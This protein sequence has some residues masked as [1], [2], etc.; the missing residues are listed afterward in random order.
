[1][2]KNIK[3]FLSLILVVMMSFTISSFAFAINTTTS[4]ST[5]NELSND[6]SYQIEC[7]YIKTFIR[8]MHNTDIII[9]DYKTLLDTNGKESFLYVTFSNNKSTGYAILNLADM[10]IPELSLTNLAPFTVDESIIYLGPLNY[11]RH[12]GSSN[13]DVRTGKVVSL[14][15]MT[16][17]S[18]AFQSKTSGT[19][20]GVEAKQ[21]ALADLVANTTLATRVTISGAGSSSWAYTAG[22]YYGDCGINAIAMIEKWYDTYVSSNYLPSNLSTEQ[23]IKKSIYDYAKSNNYPTT[24][25]SESN[26]AG[27]ITGH[28]E[29][30]GLSGRYLYA[31]YS[32]YNW[33]DTCDRIDD[34]RPTILST[35]SSTPTYGRHYIIAVGYTDDGIPSNN[36]LYVNDGWGDYVWLASSYM[37][38]MVPTY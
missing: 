34:N 35:V 18:N 30:V 15:E 11:V 23:S 25:I 10:S 33:A 3:T 20:L 27:L 31:T 5:K 19:T 28:T 7:E 12:E 24:S 38:E 8:H 36:E 21:K 4:D 13:V 6:N 16:E 17:A 2:K 9:K 14:S 1:M 26:L 22:L 32:T 29:S 37:Q